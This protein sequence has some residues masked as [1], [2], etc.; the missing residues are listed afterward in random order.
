[1]R[2]NVLYFAAVRELLNEAE[3]SIELPVEV[4]TVRDFRDH[5]LARHP[6]LRPWATSIRIARNEVFVDVEARLEDGDVLAI[7]PPVSGG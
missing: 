5:L 7:I 6:I 3:A 1:M 4:R 2:V